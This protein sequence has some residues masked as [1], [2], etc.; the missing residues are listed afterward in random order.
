MGGEVPGQDLI[1]VGLGSSFPEHPFEQG[2]GLRRHEAPRPF[3]RRLDD[4]PPPEDVEGAVAKD[5]VDGGVLGE[6]PCGGAPPPEQG[7]IDRRFPLGQSKSAEG[8]NELLPLHPDP[9]LRDGSVTTRGTSQLQF[10]PAG[11]WETL[12]WRRKGSRI[13]P[14]PGRGSPR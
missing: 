11:R 1:P 12:R 13:A 10:R 8:P 7:K 4:P 14:A 3:R 6:L 2:G 5:A 9:P